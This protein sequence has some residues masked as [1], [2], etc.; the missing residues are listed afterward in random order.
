ML[1]TLS[2]DNVYEA[3]SRLLQVLAPRC[4]INGNATDGNGNGAAP[5]AAAAPA[6]GSNGNGNG[7]GKLQAAAAAAPPADPASFAS[8]YGS[9]ARVAPAPPAPA[10]AGAGAIF[11]VP[12]YSPAALTTG[13]WVGVSVRR[14]ETRGTGGREARG[15]VRRK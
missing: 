5:A 15:S 3:E 9:T 7:N 8:P 1:T 4:D 14:L 11:T 10:P 2:N 13:A 12:E 6:P